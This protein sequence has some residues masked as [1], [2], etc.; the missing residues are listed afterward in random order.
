MLTFYLFL[1]G[2]TLG[3]FYNVVGLR[4]PEGKSIVAPGSSC[5]K[6]GHQLNALE[7]IPVFSYLIQR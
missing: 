2:L 1:I 3:S 6:C 7:L 5:P 4:V